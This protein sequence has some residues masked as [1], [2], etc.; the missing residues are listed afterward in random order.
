MLYLV[1]RFFDLL[2]ENRVLQVEI[3]ECL[4][5]KEDGN[6]VENFLQVLRVVVNFQ[7]EGRD[8]SDMLPHI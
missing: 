5:R 7:L 1:V 3:L 6:L 2:G 4:F 8:E